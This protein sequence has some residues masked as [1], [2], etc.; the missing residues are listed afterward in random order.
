MSLLITAVIALFYSFVGIRLGQSPIKWFFIGLL[1]II[2]ILLLG[3]ILISLIDN[4][5]L[6]INLWVIAHI[7]SWIVSTVIALYI[8]LK[9]L[10]LKTNR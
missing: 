3:L 5:Q 10:G 4:P 2:S 8:L 9:N 6:N 7:T 1:T